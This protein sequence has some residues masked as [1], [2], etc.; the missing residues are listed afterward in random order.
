[1]KKKELLITALEKEHSSLPEYNL[2]GEKNDLEVYVK[3]IEYLKMGKL[4]P[5]YQNS[6]LFYAIVEDFDQVCKDYGIE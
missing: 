1:M 6:D 2:F 5:D 3:I 4:P